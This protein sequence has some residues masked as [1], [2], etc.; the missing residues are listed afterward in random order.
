MSSAFTV[1]HIRIQEICFNTPD[2]KQSLM[3]LA[4][5]GVKIWLEIKKNV[6]QEKTGIL[7]NIFSAS[8]KLRYC[9]FLSRGKKY[10]F[11]MA[12]MYSCETLAAV[13]VHIQK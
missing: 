7:V 11:Q 12:E 8:D 4:V 5:M 10:V 9:S 3:E 13:K 6:I 1:F 2:T